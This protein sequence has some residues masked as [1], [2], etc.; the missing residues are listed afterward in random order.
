MWMREL[1]RYIVIFLSE[2]ECMLV[3]VELNV[4]Y[5]RAS[6]IIKFILSLH[7]LSDAKHKLN[8]MSISLQ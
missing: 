1:F 6:K 3:V 2:D 8:F 5:L 7:N 4:I